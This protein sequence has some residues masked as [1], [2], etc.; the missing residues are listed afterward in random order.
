MKHRKKSG[1]IIIAALAAILAL[2][3]VPA[4][5]L[6]FGVV[7]I[8]DPP[9]DEYPV[10]GVDV[11]EYQ[12]E[13]DWSVLSR[14]DISFAYIKATEGSGYTD[15]RFNYN[16]ENAQKTDLRIG[17]YHFFSLESKGKAQAELF[18]ETVRAVPD[19]LPPA[20]DAEPYGDHT[21]ISEKDISE[22]A[23]WLAATQE[24]FGVKP[25]IYT[26]SKWYGDLIKN[27]PDHDIWIRSVYSK[28][29]SDIEW[30]FWQYTNR[31]R[32]DGYSGEERYID[33][34][35]FRGSKEEFFGWEN[36]E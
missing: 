14:Q 32:L 25:I 3:A 7:Q 22:L 30:T 31:M 17:A 29:D 8:N 27:F 15:E 35:V 9:K 2:C 23:D 5:L 1:R 12:G 24:Y 19:M 36:K 34:N 26:T 11:S 10:R 33:M 28:P 6:W 13:I 18:C 4:A 21:D 20:V 16:W